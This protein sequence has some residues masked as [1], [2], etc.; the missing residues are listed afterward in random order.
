MNHGLKIVPISMFK[1][2]EVGDKAREKRAL[3]IHKNLFLGHNCNWI[4]WF[5]HQVVVFCSATWRGY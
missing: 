5:C 4:N 1:N 2:V 3:A